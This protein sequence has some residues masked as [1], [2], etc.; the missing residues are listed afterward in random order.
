MLTTHKLAPENIDLLADVAA[1]VFDGDIDP[2]RLSAYLAAPGHLMMA[3]TMDRQVVG[4]VTAYVHH[5]IDQASD[6]Y[7][8]NNE[9]RAANKTTDGAV[10]A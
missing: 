6:I 9:A 4:Q 2:E 8:D 1:D 5:H 7:I 10:Q 3:A